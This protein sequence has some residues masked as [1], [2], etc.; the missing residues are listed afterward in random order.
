M[1]NVMGSVCSTQKVNKEMRVQL[2]LK[3]LCE[4]RPL[5]RPRRRWKD[6]IKI[7]IRNIDYEDLK[8][9]NLGE[10]IT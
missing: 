7:G 5:G 2:W 8:R 1:D 10:Q 3:N 6:N 9:T 4:N